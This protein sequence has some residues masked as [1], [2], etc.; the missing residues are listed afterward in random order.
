MNKL[1]SYRLERKRRVRLADFDAGATP[2]SVGAKEADKARTAEIAHELAELQD[3]FYALRTTKLL[4]VLQGMDTSGKDGTIRSVFQAID[5]LG[6]RAVSYRAPTDPEKQRDFLWR[7]HRD[8]PG[9]GEVVIFNRSHYEAVLIEWVHGWIDDKER[10]RRFAA[11]CDFEHMLVDT[12]TTILKCFL[13][14]SKNEQRRRLQERIDTPEKHWKFNLGDLEERKLW[15]RYQLAYEEAL[16]QTATPFAP[17]YVVPAD[18]KTHRN[19]MVSE[20]LCAALRELA[21]SY[22]PPIKTLAGLKVR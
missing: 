8:V 5:P 21:P 9:V 7:H 15:S 12:G 2:F 10:K 19:L 11:I 3:R 14:I 20:I 22:P 1:K 6:V 13:H 4:L 17:W 16:A 18:S